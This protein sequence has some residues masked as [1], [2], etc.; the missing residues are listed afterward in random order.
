MIKGTEL[1]SVSTDKGQSENVRA[2]SVV[3]WGVLP[4]RKGINP[5]MYHL[6]LRLIV[7]PQGLLQWNIHSLFMYNLLSPRELAT[8]R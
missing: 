6:C 8:K 7:I 2:F 1:E 4:F 5:L 3:E